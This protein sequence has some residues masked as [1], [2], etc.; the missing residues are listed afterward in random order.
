MKKRKIEK[1]KISM[2]VFYKIQI[3]IHRK[4]ILKKYHYMTIHCKFDFVKEDDG[5]RWWSSTWIFHDFHITIWSSFLSWYW[6]TQYNFS[7]I[8]KIK[9]PYLLKNIISSC[10]TFS[11]IASSSWFKITKMSYKW[12]FS[13]FF[14]PQKAKQIRQ[15]RRQAIIMIIKIINAKVENDL[16]L[17]EKVRGGT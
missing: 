5:H 1:E 16:L 15:Q 6:Y 13:S 8:L 14:C 10:R 12:D 7:K 3:I 2:D 4:L 11:K 9:N 17:K